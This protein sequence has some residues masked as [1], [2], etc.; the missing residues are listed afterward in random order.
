MSDAKLLDSQRMAEFVARGFLKFDAIVPETINA[1]FMASMPS[2]E[3]WG[4][5]SC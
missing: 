1:D 2:A 3:R 4:G 5:R